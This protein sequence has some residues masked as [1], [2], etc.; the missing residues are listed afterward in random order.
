MARRTSQAL[1]A[2]DGTGHST[3]LAPQDV[4]DMRHG[5][6]V[7]G[8][9]PGDAGAAAG[10]RAGADVLAAFLGERQVDDLGADAAGVEH[11]A[12]LRLPAHER[13]P[14]RRRSA[15]RQRRS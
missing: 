7:A 2:G 1:R 13:K 6:H 5:R 3:W 10:A 12:R 9:A 4:E 15:A 14:D 11:V 8:V